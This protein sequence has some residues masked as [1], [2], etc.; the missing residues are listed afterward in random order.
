MDSGKGAAQCK[1]LYCTIVNKSDSS[2]YL[3]YSTT[4]DGVFNIGLTN[5]TDVWSTTFTL[6]SLTQHRQ[7]CAVNSTEEY[8][9]RIRSACE[10]GSVLVS[11][12]D[13]GVTLELDSPEPGVMTFVLS[14]LSDHEAQEELRVVLLGMAERLRDLESTAGGATSF[15]PAKN[16]QRRTDFEPR[17][18]QNGG[19]GSLKAAK[20]RLPGESL[21]NPGTRRK[22]QARGVAFED[23][24]S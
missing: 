5:V 15:S 22:M 10:C 11:V 16:Q 7:S 24:E 3:C 14:R 2:R 20:K 9:N 21:I 23:E 6:D 4:Q 17:R 1:P 12:Q 13:G 19:S 18:Q 8:V